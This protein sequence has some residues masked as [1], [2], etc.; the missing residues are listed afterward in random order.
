MQRNFSGFSDIMDGIDDQLGH[1][2]PVS[3]GAR[4]MPWIQPARQFASHP[5]HI[6][7]QQ[8]EG[9]RA[10]RAELAGEALHERGRR[11]GGAWEICIL[12]FDR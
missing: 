10:L 5:W 11:Q 12:L 2:V 1:A 9:P 7:A 4:S 8:Q 6:Q 3:E